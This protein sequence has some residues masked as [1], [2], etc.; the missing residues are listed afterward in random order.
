VLQRY[1]GVVAATLRPLAGGLINQTFCVDGASGR[2]VLQRVNPIFDPRIHHNIEAVTRCLSAHGVMT[3]TLLPTRDGERFVASDEDGVWRLMSYIDGVSYTRVTRPQQ[4][5]AAGALVARFHAALDELRHEFVACRTGVHDMDGHLASLEQACRDGQQHRLRADVEP[6][7]RLVLEA[8]QALP[9]L[10]DVPARIGHG[11]LKLNNI[12]FAP[13]A[14][15]SGTGDRDHALCLIDLDTVGPIALAHELGDA[16]RSWCNPAGEDAPEAVSFD[17]AI[18][19][20]AWQGYTSANP[21]APANPDPPAAAVQQAAILGVEWISLELCARFSADALNESYFGY[22]RQ[23]YPGAGEHNLT[24][25][26]AQ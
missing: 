15:D 24:R 16:L 22:D 20:A 12:I 7:A 11:D 1:E 9:P 2:L 21:D 19:E 5:F 10:P 23:R 17:M 26:R 14:G 13:P 18:F 25:A 8:A 4:A 3:P 6:L